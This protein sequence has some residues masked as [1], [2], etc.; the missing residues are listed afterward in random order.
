MLLY[1]IDLI[2]KYIKNTNKFTAT[3][4]APV[5]IEN[6]YETK[7]PTTKQKTEFIAENITTNL[8]LLQNL[9]QERTGKIIKLDIKS[10]PTIFIQTTTTTAVKIAINML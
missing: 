2:K 6:I 10:A 7:K 1:D 9:E 5:G 3:I 8:Y 4:V